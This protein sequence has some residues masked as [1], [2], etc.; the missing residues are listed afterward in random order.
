MSSKKCYKYKSKDIFEWRRR[1]PDGSYFL[2]GVI[3]RIDE[4]VY[5][6]WYVYIVLETNMFVHSNTG[7]FRVDSP[8]VRDS[9]KVGEMEDWEMTLVMLR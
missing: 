9:K 2:R 8:M 3:I 5:D 4:E 6:D 1:Y 7:F